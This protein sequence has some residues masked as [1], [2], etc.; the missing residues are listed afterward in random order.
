MCDIILIYLSPWHS[1]HGTHLNSSHLSMKRWQRS[2]KEISNWI[3]T[4]TI[5]TLFWVN[6]ISSR[7]IHLCR[8]CFIKSFDENICDDPLART[9]PYQILRRTNIRDDPSYQILRRTNIRDDPLVRTKPYQIF[10]RIN[11]RDDP[12]IRTG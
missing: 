12:L 9:K 4:A 3:R 10:R 7:V 11:I 2:E 5:C 8:F 6:L 1:S